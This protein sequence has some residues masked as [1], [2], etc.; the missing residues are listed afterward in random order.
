MKIIESV[1]DDLDTNR[2]MTEFVFRSGRFKIGIS[3]ILLGCD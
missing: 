2:H 1:T 3:S